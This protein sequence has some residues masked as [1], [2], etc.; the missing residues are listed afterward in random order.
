[1]HAPRDLGTVL[2]T[3]FSIDTMSCCQSLSAISA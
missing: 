3:S 1:M 2:T